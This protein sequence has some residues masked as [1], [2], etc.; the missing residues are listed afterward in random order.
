M[1]KI[2][3]RKLHREKDQSNKELIEL[4]KAIERNEEEREELNH[5]A[6]I[7]EEKR[8]CAF[9]GVLVFTFA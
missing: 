3:L 9:E 2:E 7:A 8:R 4:Q 5:K 1:L 6:K